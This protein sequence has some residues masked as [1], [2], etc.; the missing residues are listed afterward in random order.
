MKTLE[1]A[2]STTL[3]AAAFLFGRS[4]AERYVAPALADWLAEHHAAATGAT[5]ARLAVRYAAT[6]ALTF[7]FLLSR[8]ERDGALASA[9]PPLLVA[10]PGLVALRAASLAASQALWL[11]VGTAVFFA[12]ASLPGSR[13]TRAARVAPMLVACVA[14][15][16][17]WSASGFWR[18]PLIGIAVMPAELVKP[19]LVLSVVALVGARGPVRLAHGAAL[20]IG[21]ALAAFA[22]TS[23]P[24]PE[25]PGAAMH[26]DLA[27]LSVV[28]HAGVLGATAVALGFGA[29]LFALVRAP[30]ATG[31]AT[32]GAAGALLLILSAQMALHVGGELGLLPVLGVP[33]PFVSYG[34]SSIVGTFAAMAVLHAIARAE[35][36]RPDRHDLAQG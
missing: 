21:A 32:A 15:A 24:S 8:V 28:E 22:F 30:R 9:W 18:V 5:R 6:V 31:R 34:G 20:G 2:A 12:V 10:V 3:R 7:A 26:T 23:I 14:A 19:L 16:T 4:P 27:L 25:Q 11:A 13:L 17:V 29:L 35:L 36:P 1:H 33:L